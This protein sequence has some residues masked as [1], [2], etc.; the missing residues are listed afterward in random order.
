[1]TRAGNSKQAE[2]EYLRK[3]GSGAWER[4]KPFSPAG[5]QTLDESIRLIHDFAVAAHALALRPGHQVLDLGVGAGWTTEW[6]RRLNVRVVAVDISHDM[7]SIGSQRIPAP[8]RVVAGDLEVLPFMP[9][10]FDRALCLN[11]LH[12]LA[13]P[14]AALRE[15]HATLREHGRLVLIEPGAGHSHQDTSLRAV[16]EFGVLEQEL[17]V[18]HLMRLCHDAGFSDVAVR[19]LSYVSDEIQ[20]SLDQ[21]T[22]WNSWVR[23]ARPVRFM[24]KQWTLIQELLGTAKR[25]ALFEE[26]LGMWVSRVLARHMSEQAVVIAT[27]GAASQE[28]PPYAAVV[29]VVHSPAGAAHNLTITCR[30]V[31]SAVWRARGA[32]RVQVGIQLLDESGTLVN[33]DYAR[34]PLSSDVEPAERAVVVCDV[35]RPLPAGVLRIDLVAEDLTWFETAAP[36]GVVWRNDQ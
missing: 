14:G 7:L 10:S 3:S 34:V 17:E 22:T 1:M 11:A 31:G 2:K 24:R 4:V 27:K 21:V 36:T 19:P 20:L 6:L 5:E 16:Q 8:A 29:E 23:R 13:D 35:P 28:V 26:T 9:R 30:N 18:R 32:N 25:G 12:H 15:V 33:R